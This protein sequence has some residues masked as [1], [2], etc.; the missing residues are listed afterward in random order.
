M[1]KA[2]TIT[3][4]ES[5]VYVGLHITRDRANHA[6]TIDWSC[7]ILKMLYKFGL[8]NTSLV[9]IPA[10]PHAR[11]DEISRQDDAIITNFP[12]KDIIGS[13]FFGS[14]NTRR[15]IAYKVSSSS[16]YSDHP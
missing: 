1:G 13:L 3:Q 9:T 6:L 2:F 15:D 5:E 10:D 7:Y 8:E 4:G 12:Y 11:L 16:K 14:L